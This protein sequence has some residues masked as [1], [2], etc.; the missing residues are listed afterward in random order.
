MVPNHFIAIDFGVLIPKI[1]G[2]LHNIIP[3]I[4]VN[5]KEYIVLLKKVK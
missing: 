3:N 4:K 2:Y 5:L 1:K